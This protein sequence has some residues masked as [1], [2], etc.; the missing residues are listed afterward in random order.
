MKIRMKKDQESP[1]YGKLFKGKEYDL[2][3][4]TERAYISRGIAENISAPDYESKSTKKKTK[5]VTENG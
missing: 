1:K 2:D 5:G 4:A 3:P